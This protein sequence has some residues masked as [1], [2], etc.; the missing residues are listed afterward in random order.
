MQILERLFG[1]DRISALHE[2]N[3]SLV[4]AVSETEQKLF[5]VQLS[6]YRGGLLPSAELHFCPVCYAY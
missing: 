6:K 2:P 1:E 5:D 4:P 3:S